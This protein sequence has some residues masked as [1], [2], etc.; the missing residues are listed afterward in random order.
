M[1][2]SDLREIILFDKK[3]QHQQLQTLPT[4][5]HK[6]LNEKKCMKNYNNN[7]EGQIL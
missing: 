6:K 4:L 1:N 2:C 5:N 3:K 7:N